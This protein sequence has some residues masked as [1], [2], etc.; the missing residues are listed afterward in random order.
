MISK[1]TKLDQKNKETCFSKKTTFQK[2]ETKREKMDRHNVENR[3]VEEDPINWPPT[4][5]FY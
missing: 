1:Y 2:T 4:A 3:N 5:A